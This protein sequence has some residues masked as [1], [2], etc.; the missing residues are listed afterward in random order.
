VPAGL[1]LSLPPDQLRAVLQHEMAHIA[2]RDLCIGLVQRAAAIAYWWNPLVLLANRQLADLREQICDDIAIRG[3]PEPGAYAATLINLA[4]RC[5]QSLPVSATLGIGSSPAGQLESRIRR[6]LSSSEPRCV[7]LTRVAAAGVSAAVL[8]ITATILLAQV[9]IKSPA[10]DKPGEQTQAGPSNQAQAAPAAQPQPVIAADSDIAE[11][12]VVESEVAEPAAAE[13]PDPFDPKKW[14]TVGVPGRVVGPDGQPVAGA[15]IFLRAQY[16]VRAPSREAM[17]DAEGR[18]T[19]NTAR[20]LGPK[21]NNDAPNPVVTK[22]VLPLGMTITVTETNNYMGAPHTDAAEIKLIKPRIVATAPGFGFGTLS[23]GDDV[24]INLVADEPITGRITDEAGKPLAGAGVRVRDVLWPRRADDPIALQE[25]RRGRGNPAP[26]IPKGEGLDPWLAAIRRAANMNEYYVARGYLVGLIEWGSLGD[27]PAVHAPLVPPVTTDADGR[28]MLKGLGRERVAEIYVDGVPDKASKLI[29]IVNR[30]LDQ[31]I[32]IADE[33]L[34]AKKNM[35]VADTDLAVFGNKVEL[36]LAPGR[37]IEG[38]VTDRV[39]GAPLPGLPVVGPTVTRLEYRGFDRFFATTDEQGRYRIDS[40]PVMRQARFKVE[41]AQWRGGARSKESTE[42]APYFGR[43]M[44]LNIEPGAGP[45]QVDF[46]LSKGI[47][48]TGKVVDDA[49]GE[50]LGGQTIAYAVFKANPF[51]KKDLKAGIRPE[52]DDNLRTNQDGTF[53]LRAYPGRG[54]VTAGGGGDYLE[55]IGV[56]EI[57]G[58]KPDEIYETLYGHPNCLSTTIEVN[59][60]EDV[61]IFSCEVRLK[62]GKSRR[63]RVVGPNGRPVTDLEASGLSN[64]IENPMSEVE[65]SFFNVTNL[66]PGESR[67]VVARCVPRKLTGTAVVT[68]QGDGPVTLKLVPWAS[69]TGRLVDDAGQPRFRGL[70]IQLEDGNL[71]IHTLNG[72]NYDKEEFLIDPDGKFHIEGLVPGATYR[73]QVDEGSFRILGD[74][75]DDFTLKP[76]ETRDFGDVKVMKPKD[77]R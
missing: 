72:L 7:R 69:L 47:W 63:V 48:I 28:F 37:T 64:Q 54:I 60:P 26:P 50:G 33:T 49:T 73:L 29:L 66:L 53:K 31:T 36:S 62:K 5:S 9:Q 34:A 3:L 1:V 2:R 51:L 30:P 10:K 52:F 15:M 23:P 74:V 70:R 41:P 19:F 14:G 57:V 68:E 39:T 21:L 59:V 38:V 56:G 25:D 6:I 55:G 61:T 17:T 71:P 11:A 44:Y 4:E 45:Q 65:N 27:K 75:T 46:P 16:G 24:T 13:E 32:L 35:T 40:F 22:A 42:R 67:E 12:E 43:E 20:R 76:G 8:L 58:L 77:G 18:F